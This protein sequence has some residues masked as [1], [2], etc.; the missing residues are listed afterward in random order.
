MKKI[1]LKLKQLPKISILK[2]GYIA[3]SLVLIISGLVFIFITD[4]LFMTIVLSLVVGLIYQMGL[5]IRDLI[6]EDVQ[7]K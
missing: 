1:I 4:S 3:N 5:L 2:N 7:Y 6:K